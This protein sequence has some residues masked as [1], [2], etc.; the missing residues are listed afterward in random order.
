MVNDPAYLSSAPVTK[1][2]RVLTRRPQVDR[3]S[4]RIELKNDPVS[5][6]NDQRRQP[7]RV[8]SPHGRK[9]VLRRRRLQGVAVATASQGRHLRARR[10]RRADRHR[11]HDPVKVLQNV[12][13][14]Y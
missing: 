4:P 1:T 2:K 11:R 5:G 12:R 3:S 6:R 14:C 8:Q 7:A 13:L 10:R 9:Q